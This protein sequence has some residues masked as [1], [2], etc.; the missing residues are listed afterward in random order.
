MSYFI[1]SHIR[2]DNNKIFYIGK[3]NKKRPYDI[4]N[5]NRYWHHVVNKHGFTVQIIAEHEKEED[6]YKHEKELIAYHKSI[7]S[8]LV[9]L[10]DGGEGASGMPKS[11]ETKA[12]ISK[13][14]K[15]RLN[16]KIKGDLN[17]AKRIESR[18]KRS[19]AMKEFYANGGKNPMLGKKRPDLIEFNKTHIKKG[20]NNFKSRPIFVNNI[21][22]ESI[23]I[24]SKEIGIEAATLRWRAINQPIKYNT[25][26]KV[27]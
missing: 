26:F 20:L 6:A 18:I 9:N 10:T 3:G 16:P 11:E 22:Y 27:N 17:P 25:H 12:K 13:A 23:N 1:Y 14:N 19:I 4:Y 2:N 15:G 5:R 24:A 8:P 21:F 7:G